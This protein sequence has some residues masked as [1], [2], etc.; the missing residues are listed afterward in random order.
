MPSSPYRPPMPSGPYGAAINGMYPGNGI[1][2]SS[3]YP[4]G[5]PGSQMIMQRSGGGEQPLLPFNYY[6]SSSDAG[7]PMGQVCAEGLC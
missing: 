7:G 4:I 3:P 5:P 2:A 6:G 1:A